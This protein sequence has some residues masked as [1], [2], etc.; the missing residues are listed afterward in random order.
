MNR[1]RLLF[2]SWVLAVLTIYSQCSAPEQQCL[3]KISLVDKVT[4]H[5][6]PG[7]I[8]CFLE[9]TSKAI[10]INELLARGQGVGSV[11]LQQQGKLPPRRS[12]HDWYVLPYP[13]EIL[14]PQK[15]IYLE[16]F[17]GLETE[18]SGL[19]IDLRG[20]KQVTIKLSVQAFKNQLRQENWY[21]GNTHLHLF[22]L[23]KDESDRYLQE[24]PRADRLD[25][26]FTSYLIR[27]SEDLH[28]I[29]NQY[30]IGDLKEFWKTGVLLNQGEEHRHNLEPFSEGYG[31]VMLLN[32]KKLIEP[33]SI[34]PGITGSGNDGIPLQTG[35]NETHR[36]GGTAI[37]CHNTHGL[38]RVASFANKTVRIQN[39]FDGYSP[40]NYP[41][42]EDT[43]Y[44]YLN[45]G[46]RISFSTGTDWFLSDF[47]RVYTQV[48]GDLSIE[49][50]LEALW[51]GRSFITNGPLFHFQVADQNIGE[52]VSLDKAQTI[53]IEGRALG[54][55]DF[56]KL[57]LIKNGNVIQQ[58]SSQKEDQHFIA[59][60]N[61]TLQLNNPSWL[62]LRVSSNTTTEYG[63]PIFGH[64]SPIY[65]N[66]A[67]KSVHQPSA[68][69]LL[70]KQ[71]EKNK[72]I[73][74]QKA[75]FA[76]SQEREMVLKVYDQGLQALQP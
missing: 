20:K 51:K 9:G 31:H 32:I 8:R 67:E 24:I 39:I 6:I 61:Q 64:T 72:Q 43:F 3:V 2:I 58:F 49:N 28:Y 25:L 45:A 52:T 70:R 29:T 12:I 4:Q 65:I 59:N 35:I 63:F 7:V 53:K 73:V 15:S 19:S 74:A 1:Q 33:V 42:Y 69:A 66:I 37:W 14:L 10:P 68:V 71:I 55:V 48:N 38:E 56:E 18:K 11:A 23:S 62:A 44:H 30:P 40:D 47:S 17:S 75:L 54:R 16:G 41:R 60:F 57:E 21:G 5:P 50:W 76:T 13:K 34:G 22:K 27:P 46:L 36:Q 26:L